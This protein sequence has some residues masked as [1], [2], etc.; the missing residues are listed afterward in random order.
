M[1]GDSA[2]TETGFDP[3]FAVSPAE[4][5]SRQ[6]KVREFAQEQGFDAAVVWSRGGGFVDMHADVLYLTNH[7]SQQPYMGDEAG[8]GAGRSHGVCILP[9][10]GPTIL[11]VDIPWWRQDLVVAD[12]VSPSIHIPQAVASELRNLGIDNGRLAL[13]GASYMTAAAYLGLVSEIPTARFERVDRLVERLRLHKSPAE[14]E[15][16][17][18]ACSL[19]SRT[20]D[21]LMENVVEGATEAEALAAGMHVLT[22]GGGVL[23]DAAC[24]SGPQAGE[25]A[26]ARL[27]SADPIRRLEDGDI[28]HVDMY[29]VYGG[30]LFDL[31]RSRVVG[32]Q[33][34]PA[35][36]D[37][38][39]AA[40]AGVET[41]CRDVRSGMTGGEVY[42]SADRWLKSI[43]GLDSSPDNSE[44][45]RFPAVGHGV[46]LGWEAPWMMPGDENVIE[47][48]M[49]VAVELFLRHSA[50]GGV[51][52]EENGFVNETG[53]ERLT[54]ARIR[55]W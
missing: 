36:K 43:E 27:P 1:I 50:I 30:Y 4:F 41:I 48:G 25:Y 10:D 37:F 16:I 42:A 46:G 2:A 33:P 6:A 21:T 20:M 19:G 18:R 32:D 11:I 38:L 3:W 45:E 26:H 28:F 7:Y 23:L 39:E 53:F 22:T 44:I 17:R 54:D 55:W 31:A 34:T 47:P 12:Q 52:F 35:Q 9:G 51:M 49:H 24:T 40:I 29:G 14:Q 5:R 15:I 8:I 13:V